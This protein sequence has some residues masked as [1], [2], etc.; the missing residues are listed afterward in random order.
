MPPVARVLPFFF[1]VLGDLDG[2]SYQGR[3][4]YTATTRV[5]GDLLKISVFEQ[6]CVRSFDIGR[7]LMVFEQTPNSPGARNK[8][9]IPVIIYC[10]ICMVVYHRYGISSCQQ[11]IF[12]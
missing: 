8:S 2:K 4:Y 12:I 10:C 9:S 6:S 7:L 11:G 1:P 5:A 3:M